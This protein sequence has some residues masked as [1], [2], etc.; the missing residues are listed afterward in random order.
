MGRH[1]A[2]MEVSRNAYR[3]SVGRSE[4]KRPIGRP[5]YRWEDNIKIYLMEVDC[6]AGKWNGTY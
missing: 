3:V 6:D 2:R 5:R 4:G 1:V